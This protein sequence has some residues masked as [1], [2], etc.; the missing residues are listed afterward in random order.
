MVNEARHLG[1]N[2]NN[3]IQ[4]FYSMDRWDKSRLRGM[5]Q[6]ANKKGAKIVFVV[7]SQFPANIYSMVKIY[8]RLFFPRLVW[9]ALIV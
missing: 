5:F 9:R 6:D 2:L 8:L 7:I 4:P 3:G 1:L